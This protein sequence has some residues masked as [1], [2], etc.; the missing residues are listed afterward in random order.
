MFLIRQAK[1][2][3]VTTLVKLARMV[4]FINLPPDD[5]LIHD[6]IAQSRRSFVRAAGGRPEESEARGGRRKRA[7]GHASVAQMDQDSEV[8]VFVLEDTEAGGVIGTSQIRARQ[9]GPGNPNWS[10]E[11]VEKKFSSPTLGFGTTHTAARLHGDESGPTEIGGL[12]L[13][14]SHRGHRA[15]PGRFLSFVRFHFIGLFRQLFAER[16]LAEMMAPVTHDG[17]NLFW[18]H[19]G[20]KFI[21]VKYAEA[22]TWT[23]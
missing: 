15:R 11:L 10:L 12:I 8:F 2:D 9:G 4:Y 13:S 16:V 7:A 21:P 6:K 18:D 20:R 5:R 3:D 17:D 22:R 19:V 14:P 1:P 23:P